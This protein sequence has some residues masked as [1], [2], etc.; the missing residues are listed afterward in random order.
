LRRLITVMFS[1]AVL[2]LMA[3]P[4]NT[5]AGK[6]K[7]TVKVKGLRTPADIVVYLPKAPAVDVDLSKTKFVMD[8]QN[9]AFIP[10]VLPI[11]VGSTVLFPNNDKVDHNVFSMSRTKT[12]N[13]GSYEP[14]Q[15]QTVVFD[16]PGIVEVRCDVHAEMAAYI[17]VMKNPYFA[18][19]DRKG[20]F[21]IPDSG[22]LQQVGLEGIADLPPGKYSIKTRHEKLKTQK[23]SIVVPDSGDGT[24]ELGLKR[25][26]P[27]VLY[28]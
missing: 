8:Q 7:G 19:T 12:F 24:V 22:Y 26:V 20:N 18:V 15:S 1:L 3:F 23:K 14:G 13:L 2:A 11:P 9:L 21:E 27:S 25:G 10:R 16:K 5:L 4:A 28:K 6:I 17:L